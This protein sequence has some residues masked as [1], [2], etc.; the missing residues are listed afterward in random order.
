M[1]DE[2]RLYFVRKLEDAMINQDRDTLMGRFTR[3]LI[4]I[5]TKWAMMYSPDDID[6]GRV[7]Q[8]KIVTK[9]LNLQ[10]DE[11]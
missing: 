5:I 2:A 11:I 7:K 4:K 1:V 9:G 10:A 3:G 6:A 8:T